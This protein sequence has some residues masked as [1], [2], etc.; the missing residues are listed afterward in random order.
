MGWELEKHVG[1]SLLSCALIVVVSF[2]GMR[3]MCGL[4]G[5]AVVC[6]REATT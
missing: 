1:D 5:I 6:Q 4:S 3:M 2:R